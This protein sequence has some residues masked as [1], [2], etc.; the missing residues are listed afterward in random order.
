MAQRFEKNQELIQ[1]AYENLKGIP[2]N[3]DEYEKMISGMH[4]HCWTPELDNARLERHEQARQYGD[5]SFR[6][7]ETTAEFHKARYEYLKKIFGKV[8][9]EVNSLYIEP[10][11]NIDYGFN[12]SLGE[13]FYANF[14]LTILD[15]SIVKIGD[16]V[17]CGPNVTLSCASH[18][19]EPY[20][21]TIKDIEWAR[22]ITIG[23][24]AWLGAGVTVLGG[25][26]IGEG[27]VIG[28]NSVVTK[29]IPPYT[30]YA[31]TPARF[32]KNIEVV[33]KEKQIEELG[34]VRFGN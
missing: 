33:S 9:D 31:G 24:A 1:Y 29:D 19:L 26:T 11:F 5:I 17:M 10:P 2:L 18:S 12:V 13:R 15:C 27:A 32:I 22:E 4:Y 7:F 25:V 30:V 16:Y 14:N 28:A 3:S 8:G 6:D 23:D 20:E 34:K 21:R